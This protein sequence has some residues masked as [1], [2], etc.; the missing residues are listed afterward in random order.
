VTPPKPA[1]PQPAAL[2]AEPVQVGTQVGP[3][4]LER[5]LGEGAMG[6][7]FAARHVDI[8]R[9]AAVKVLKVEHAASEE[10]VR[11]FRQEAQV[12]NAVRD[13]HLV[14]VHDFAVVRA[15]QGPAL[16]YCVM[17]QL[18]GEALSETL[19][20]GPVSVQRTASIGQQLATALAAAHR[21]GVVHRDIKPENVFL[22]RRAGQPDFVKVLDFGVAKLRTP[23]GAHPPTGT[24]TGTVVGTPEYLSPE[25]AQGLAVD[26]RG[27]HYAV[28]LVL[29]ELLAGA[30]PFAGDT[31]GK[32]VVQIVSQPAP[33]LPARTPGREPIPPG[34]A[35]VVARCL[36]K[37][38]E[39]R[40]QSG[41]ALAR[42][43]APYAQAAGAVTQPVEP[44]PA[45]E[46]LEE[47]LRAVRPS[48]WPRVLVA[49]LGLLV[50]SSLGLALAWPEQRGAAAEAPAA[51]EVAEVA[52][53]VLSEPSG[54]EVR[55][56]DTGEVL[57]RTPLHTRAVGGP[58][59]LVL[60]LEGYG[61]ERRTVDLSHPARLSVPLKALK[62]TQARH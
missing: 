52:L 21:V 8:G 53:D 15:G 29:Y 32:L 3:W 50:L 4:R 12:V 60:A 34:L 57:G 37:A 41:E 25:Q 30:Q 9:R 22:Q 49:G 59:W 45:P 58:T 46:A 18:E 61:A 62:R 11:R 24:L 44:L 13:P 28:G 6:R 5:L 17:E 7:V 43:L 26:W 48:L 31:F 55:R 47:Q 39:A 35:Q 19:N 54:A 36:E 20:R 14:E 42:A 2:P 38:P 27:D 1:Q 56:A 10:V 40:W 33:P 51:L 23:L 16:V